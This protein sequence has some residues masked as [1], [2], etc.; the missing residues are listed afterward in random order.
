[1]FGAKY[2]ESQSWGSPLGC[3]NFKVSRDYREYKIQLFLTAPGW[4]SRERN[5]TYNCL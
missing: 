3:L 2:V 1:L 4:V 5:P